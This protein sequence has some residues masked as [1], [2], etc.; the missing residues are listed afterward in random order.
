M[1]HITVAD[2]ILAGLVAAYFAY[3][4]WSGWGE[5]VIYGDGD[6]DVRADDH[7]TAFVLTALSVVM[8][9]AICL[10]IALGSSAGDLATLLAW[11]WKV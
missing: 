7:P 5:G 2:R 3:R 8:V 9:I 1:Q 10:I 6:P 11:L 4:L